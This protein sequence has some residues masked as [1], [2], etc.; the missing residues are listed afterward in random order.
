MLDKTVP[1]V[2]NLIKRAQRE[3]DSYTDIMDQY[4]PVQH[5]IQT[6]N[7]CGSHGALWLSCM[8][9]SQYTVLHI[10]KRKAIQYLDNAVKSR[11]KE[12]NSEALS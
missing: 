4:L 7:T 12:N 5:R 6:I 1:I 2:I 8:L 9:C 11:Q 3:N 10:F